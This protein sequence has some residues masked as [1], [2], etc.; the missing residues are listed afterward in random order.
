MPEFLISLI[1]RL[2]VGLLIGAGAGVA[3]VALGRLFSFGYS[4]AQELLAF[5]LFVL[6]FGGFSVVDSIHILRRRRTSRASARHTDE[7]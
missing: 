2:S 4:S 6:L 5:F 1:C 7:S 3:V